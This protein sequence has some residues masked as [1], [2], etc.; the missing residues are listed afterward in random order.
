[1]KLVNCT[2]CFIKLCNVFG[3]TPYA[4]VPGRFKWTR[5]RAN[6][7]RTISFLVIIIVIFL[8]CTIF[9]GVII[10]YTDPDLI[11][12]ILVYTIL[13]ICSNAF[14]ILLE[15][16]LKRDQHIKL[17]N[18][19]V[20]LE[21]LSEH[22]QDVELDYIGL[23]RTIRRV[24]FFW[25][26]E[27]FGLF[28][29]NILVLINTMDINDVCF[30]L[31]FT[32]PHLM[33]KLSCS[34]WIV[35]VAILHE[36][37]ISLMTYTKKLCV[38]HAKHPDIPPFEIYNLKY[39]KTRGGKISATTIEFL[40]RC[41]CSIWEASNLLND[42]VFWSFP[43]GFLNEFSLLVFNCFFFIRMI[44][45]SE[46]AGYISIVQII[47]SATANLLNIMLLTS[48]CETTTETVILF[49]NWHLYSFFI[50]I[51]LLNS[52]EISKAIYSKNCYKSV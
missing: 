40:S 5:N 27:T 11:V 34:Y 14:L 26:F 16:F 21:S 29:L 1:M 12:A 3:L 44:Q 4:R 31:M 51:F 18:L 48:S 43:I 7:M 10:D 35:L 20:K 13:I 19:F 45:L 30:V 46:N 36:N 41:Y 50:R 47:S 52:G 28:S 9:N 49:K 23:K 6:E 24:I 39:K 25:T 38:N 37:V 32:L 2:S 8:L 22:Y 17:F 42:I 15:T 33:N